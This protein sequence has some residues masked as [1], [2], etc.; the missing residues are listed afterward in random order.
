MGII[1]VYLISKLFQNI[2]RLINQVPLSIRFQ[3]LSILSIDYQGFPFIKTSVILEN[4]L[5]S[6]CL[7]GV[8]L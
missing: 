4:T 8:R 6:H 1:S 3:C 7:A 5:Q 2:Q